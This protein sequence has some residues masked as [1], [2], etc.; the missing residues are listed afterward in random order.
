MRSYWFTQYP[1]IIRRDYTTIDRAKLKGTFAEKG[2][3]DK[4]RGNIL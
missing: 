2:S 3:P 1:G 4:P